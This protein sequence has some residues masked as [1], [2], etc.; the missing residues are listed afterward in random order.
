MPI[1]GSIKAHLS[2]YTSKS[3]SGNGLF[4]CHY[5][6]HILNFNDH[7]GA[8]PVKLWVILPSLMMA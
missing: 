3:S 6:H 7:N 1:N 5:D 8:I 2:H 4:D